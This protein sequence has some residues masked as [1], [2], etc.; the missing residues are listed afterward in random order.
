MLTAIQHRCLVLLSLANDYDAIHG[1]LIEHLAHHIDRCLVS[2]IL[3]AF[4]QPVES[5]KRVV[6]NGDSEVND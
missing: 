6:D 4:A 3:V 5:S 1:D 2:S